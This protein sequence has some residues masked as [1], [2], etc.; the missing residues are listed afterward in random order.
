MG[1]DRAAERSEGRGWEARSRPGVRAR[2]TNGLRAAVPDSVSRRK[3]EPLQADRDSASVSGGNRREEVPTSPASSAGVGGSSAR[4]FRPRAERRQAPRSTGH[5]REHDARRPQR[6]FYARVEGVVRD[7]G[8]FRTVALKDVVAR[9]F[10]GHPF[11]ARQ[12][13]ALAERRG[14]IERRE[15]KGPKGGGYTV[16]VATPAGAARAAALWRECDR[17]EQRAHS[18]VVKPAEL[19]HDVAVYRA[20][21]DAQ[22]RIEAK[23]GR[24]TRVR[25]DAELKGL[26]AARGE[27]ARQAQ[28]AV[29]AE[30]ERQRAAA[31]LGLPVRDGKVLVPDA[32]L[33]YATA[34]G[35]VGRCNVEVASEHYNGREIRAKAAAGF[36]MYAA[37]GRAA[38]VVRR[39]L[40]GGSGRGSGG[41]ILDEELF[42]L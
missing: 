30:A 3:S 22:R 27:R 18:G 14:W 7:V 42:E 24:V 15:A 33:E 25:I 28:G 19:A 16:L 1:R 29:A 36:Q 32:Q 37:A 10:D 39:A 5:R 2:A 41:G 34:A 11:V 40:G 38:E 23:G 13:I 17:S 35:D 6:S 4:D 8:A 20:A 31:D 21:L 26:V 12:G 9:Q